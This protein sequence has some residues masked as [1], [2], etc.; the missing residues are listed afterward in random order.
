[1]TR[2]TRSTIEPKDITAIEFECKECG[3]KTLRKLDKKLQ[4]PSA[5]GN[6]SAS[7]FIDGRP[8]HNELAV[9]CAKLEHYGKSGFPYVLRFQVPGSE[10]KQ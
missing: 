4:I 10:E 3:T 6:C 5:C 2:E 8:E 7:W 1:V 9:F